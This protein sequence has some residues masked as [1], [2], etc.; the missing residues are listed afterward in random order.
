MRG[1]RWVTPAF[2]MTLMTRSLTAEAPTAA[3]RMWVRLR[4]RWRLMRFCS[5]A[6][7]VSLRRRPLRKDCMTWA[8]MGGSGENG[9]AA[10][11]CR[12]RTVGRGAGGEEGADGYC[13]G[14]AM[15]SM[16]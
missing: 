13:A 16:P 4:P 6:G 5:A 8:D 1:W 12:E 2:F 11:R 3:A 9:P 7:R 14:L 10:A 15:S